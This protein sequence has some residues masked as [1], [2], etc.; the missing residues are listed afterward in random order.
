MWINIIITILIYFSISSIFA[1]LYH[2]YFNYKTIGGYWGTV[3]VGFLGATIGGFSLNWIFLR[4]SDILD[5]VI[6]IINWLMKNTDQ[7]ILPPVNVI[8]AIFGAYLF[9]YLLKRMTPQ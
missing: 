3:F 5:Y 8:A 7:E 9:V 6:K 4:L 1:S 2:S